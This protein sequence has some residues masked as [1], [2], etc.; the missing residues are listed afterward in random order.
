MG[1]DGVNK[2]QAGMAPHNE[3]QVNYECI[4]KL[5]L[6]VVLFAASLIPCFMESSMIRFRR[7]ME[8]DLEEESE[9]AAT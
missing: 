4:S 2:S 8:V 9:N 1:L 7:A 5:V 6:S 3:A